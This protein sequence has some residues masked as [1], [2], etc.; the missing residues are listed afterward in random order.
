MDEELYWTAITQRDRIYDDQFVYAVRTTGVYCRPSCASR[1][2]RRSNV[3]FFAD[4]TAAEQAGFR[5][6]KRCQPKSSAP[7]DEQRALVADMCRYLDAPHETLPTLAELGAR[8]ALSPHHLQRVF[9]RIVGV[10]PRQYADARRQERLK[11]QLKQGDDVTGALFDAGY[12]SSSS[13]Y[14][15][16]DALGMTPSDYRQGGAL[17]LL[18]AATERG[19]AKVSLG[20]DAAALEAE[21]QHEF[22]RATLLRDEDGLGQWVAALLGYLAGEQP[23]LELPL[24]IQATAFQRKVYDALRAIPYGSTRSYQQVAAAIGQPTATRAVASACAHNPVALIIPCH[25]VVRADGSLSGYRWGIAR[26]QAILEREAALAEV[27]K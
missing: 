20:D 9:T 23:S 1:Q 11:Q 22:P 16:L 18:V 3:A 27:P 7:R 25:R 21:L 4:A 14:M 13:F 19:V 26:K 12:G 17:Q 5:A 2:P 6:C 24:D 15:Q 10:S 8:F